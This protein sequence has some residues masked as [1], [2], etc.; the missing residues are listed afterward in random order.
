MT[1]DTPH[2]AYV[3]FS[4]EDD[5]MDTMLSAWQ[6]EGL[7]CAPAQWDAV[8]VDWSSFDA[9]VVRSVWD[10]SWRHTEFLA[11]ASTVSRQTVLLNSNDVLRR[12]SDKSYLR[13][14]ASV[15]VPV[16]PT[17]WFPASQP[18]G[19]ATFDTALEEAGWTEVVVKPTVSAG[20]RNT[21]R[22]AEP[23]EALAHANRLTASGRDVM[24]QP[25]VETVESEGETSL[26]YF[27]GE[28]SHAVRRGP[29]LVPEATHSRWQ[30]NPRFPTTDQLTLAEQVLAAGPA[31]EE[32]F[33][34]RVDLVRTGAGE[35]LLMELELIEPYLFLDHSNGAADR[36]A[37]AL[38]AK[39][40][41][42]AN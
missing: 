6:R 40:K 27:G 35:L 42:K 23:Q 37:S 24:V 9:A 1:V 25:Y 39:L 2:V 30:V 32:V 41:F 8:E 14:L 38:A 17:C 16:I 31:P 7:T 3:T 19:R 5:E 11:W 18:V 21:I 29:M 10:Y 20:A 28:F 33:C 34:A 36:F 22:T 26:L 15:G 12:N 13:E 4:G